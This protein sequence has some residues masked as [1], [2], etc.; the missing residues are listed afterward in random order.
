M[1][2]L[3]IFSII[4]LILVGVGLFWLWRRVL[5]LPVKELKIGN[6]NITVEIADTSEARAL[7]LSYRE[8]LP[9]ESGLLFIFEKESIYP[10]WMKGM[11]FPI[12][13]IW[14]KNE[15]VLE[16]TNN[17]EPDKGLMPG[18]Y[19][20]RE[21]VEKVLEINAGKVKEWNIKIN[22]AISLNN[23]ILSIVKNNLEK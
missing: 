17:V 6:K 18:I 22:D 2:N 23:S 7:G 16:I 3:L 5:T 11:N 12:D 10:F 4:V 21:P 19:T 15:K 14:I 20:P 9:P 13:I 8:S 1:K